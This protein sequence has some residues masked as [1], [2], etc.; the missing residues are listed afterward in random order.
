[1]LRFLRQFT[2]FTVV[3]AMTGVSARAQYGW[4]GWGGGGTSAGGFAR[5]AGVMAAG[6]GAYNEQTA[7]ARSV[8]ASTYMQMNTYLGV[9]NQNCVKSHCA[10]LAKNDALQKETA[11][12][13]YKRLH[14]NPTPH[15][16]HTGDAL[17]IVLEE[18]TN[19]NVYSS[20]VQK[21]TQPIPSDM[22]K[23]IEFQ[24]AA[25][26]IVISLDDLSANG[27][28][29]VLLTTAEIAPER[30][31][32]RELVAKAKQEVAAKGEVSAET[33]AN[34]R[35][36]ITAAKDKI[37]AL[38]PQGA[39][40]RNKADNY[41]KALYGLTKMLKTPNVAPFLKDL[42]KMPTTELGRLLSFMHSFNLRFGPAKTP[43]QEATYDQLYPMLVALRDQSQ[44]RSQ[45][46]ITN[47]L[48]PQDPKHV[49]AYFGGMDYNQVGAPTGRR[50]GVAPPPPGQP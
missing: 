35:V 47:P 8:N 41:L 39:P 48:P 15:D 32:L 5:G 27:V 50:S 22:V 37:D 25:D 20:L 18:L 3:L 11:T 13:T 33:L 1:M 38:L 14:D 43:L 4:G 29:D 24:Y 26:M 28:P 34:C 2:L 23:N 49:T 9:C 7:M 21:S 30:K 46:P 16:V 10:L 17:N 44:V 42:D 36:T 45:N 12:S 31:T 40:D 19:P 6:A